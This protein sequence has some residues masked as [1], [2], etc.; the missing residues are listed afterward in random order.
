MQW[1]INFT[2]TGK[3]ENIFLNLQSNQVSVN[4]VLGSK[5]NL[6]VPVMKAPMSL[7]FPTL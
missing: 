3:V 1:V 5:G 6:F 4:C 2:L 7:C